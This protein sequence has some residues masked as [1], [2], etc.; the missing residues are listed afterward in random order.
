MLAGSLPVVAISLS[1]FS[2]RPGEDGVEVTVN[3]REP[4]EPDTVNG[5]LTYDKLP[6]TSVL[7]EVG[8]PWEIV[9][10]AEATV[11]VRIVEAE[12]VTN[13]RNPTNNATSFVPLLICAT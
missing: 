7:S 11:D 13:M 3:D 9:P 5:A 8:A 12:T 1:L 6:A 2:T 10:V 4:E